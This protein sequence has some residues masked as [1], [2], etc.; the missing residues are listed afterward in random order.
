MDIK[1]LKDKI[2]VLQSKMR[3]MGYARIYVWSVGNMTEWICE[4]AE[5]EAW[6]GYADI[7]ATIRNN[8]HN[9]HTVNNKL[10]LLRVIQRFD[11]EGALPDGR[12]HNRRT[13]RYDNLNDEYKGIV[14]FAW[15]RMDSSKEHS[16]TVRCAL[17]GFLLAVQTE[18]ATSF[19]DIDERRVLKAL[20]KDNGEVKSY[21]F[22]N[23][24]AEGLRRCKGLIPAEATNRV[25]SFLPCIPHVRK[26]IQFLTENEIEAVKDVL[27]RDASISLMDKAIV[28]LAMYTGLRSG[29]IAALTFKNID[30]QND[31]MS[32]TQSKTGMP[33]SI[34]LRAVVGN[35][36]LDY[37]ENE[38]PVCDVPQIF[39]TVNHPYRR[40]HSSNLGVI[41]SNVMRKAGIR[42]GKSDRRGMH[43]FRHHVATAMLGTG[44]PQPVISATLGHASPDSLN[45]YLDAELSSLKE[46]ALSIE[47]YPVRK[48]VFEAWS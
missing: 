27:D 22:R 17:T 34:P 5:A 19:S 8:W 40:L 21:S 48:E 36:I 38:R 4:N 35:A 12:K 10:R 47:R 32:I 33:L 30:W 41:C 13:S 29:D 45:H 46:C 23:T 1:N 3:D 25:I 6:R 20:Q 14:D 7:Q 15:S 9:V 43:L 18:G 2:S 24:V 28:T 31:L 16:S 11:E 26:N 39:V 42:L 44:V 37:V